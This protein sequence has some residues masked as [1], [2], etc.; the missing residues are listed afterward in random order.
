MR[1]CHLIALRH[2]FTQLRLN[3]AQAI[4]LPSLEDLEVVSTSMFSFTRDLIALEIRSSSSLRQ[5]GEGEE[6]RR[7][8]RDR[9]KDQHS[10]TQAPTVY[11]RFTFMSSS[12]SSLRTVMPLSFFSISATCFS[13][14]NTV[15]TQQFQPQLNYQQPSVHWLAG[16]PQDK[17]KVGALTDSS[18]TGKLFLVFFFLKMYFNRSLRVFASTFTQNKIHV[19]FPGHC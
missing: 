9:E 10:G 13:I 16:I 8:K 7:E 4:S 15:T 5:E 11:A 2:K 6:G 17:T 19:S 18:S 1:H 14:Y 12:T 3:N